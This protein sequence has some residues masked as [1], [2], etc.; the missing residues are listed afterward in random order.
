MLVQI[1]ARTS[2]GLLL[3]WPL[4][5]NFNGIP[6]KNIFIQNVFENVVRKKCRLDFS[7]L[8]STSDNP[9]WNTGVRKISWMNTWTKLKEELCNFL[10][11]E[12][13]ARDLD[14]VSISGKTSYC[15]ISSRCRYCKSRCREIC[16]Y[17]WLMALKF[18]RH[19]GR[20]A[21]EAPIKFQ[22][23]AIIQTINHSASRLHEI[24]R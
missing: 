18:D 4:G 22:S 14:P 15:K 10:S 19:L 2:A 1:V 16:L 7:V 12:R 3:S 8:N 5:T 6:I 23:D 21:A 24:L 11:I 20:S 13:E 17:N 9:C